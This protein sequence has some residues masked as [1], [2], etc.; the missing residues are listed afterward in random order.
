[1]RRMRAAITKWTRTMKPLQTRP[2]NNKHVMDYLNAVEERRRLSALEFSLRNH[3]TKKFWK[4]EA[5]E[6][7]G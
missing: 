7:D 6:K 5:L 4:R 2:S 1:M 3:A